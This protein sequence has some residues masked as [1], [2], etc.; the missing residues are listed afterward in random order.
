VESLHALVGERLGTAFFTWVLRALILLIDLVPILFKTLSLLGRPTAA[1]L[2]EEDR[3]DKWRKGLEARRQHKLDRERQAAEDTAKHERTLRQHDREKA[4]AHSE[5]KV[6]EAKSNQRLVSEKTEELQKRI[7][8]GQ[9][10]VAYTVIDAWKA[11]ALAAVPDLMR[12]HASSNGPNPP[13]PTPPAAASAPGRGLDDD[14]VPR[15]RMT[16]RA[17]HLNGASAS[18]RN[19][20]GAPGAS[21]FT[22]HDVSTPAPQAADRAAPDDDGPDA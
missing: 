6:L 1:E 19:R 9:T 21:P 8:E 3:E 14:N 13:Q 5:L 11:E 22:Q 18:T 10:Q 2:D 7:L 15:G 12:A 4:E 20:A 16:G 17:D